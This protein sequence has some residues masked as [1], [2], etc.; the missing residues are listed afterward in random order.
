MPRNPSAQ[1]GLN[2]MQHYKRDLSK[3]DPEPEAHQQWR[4]P[5]CERHH[6]NEPIDLEVYR[7]RC[8]WVGDRSLLLTIGA[9]DAKRQR[10]RANTRS[11]E[12]S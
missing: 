3:C 8:G 11:S 2:S 5:A 9:T 6:F 4:C 10:L 7:C 1:I 12:T